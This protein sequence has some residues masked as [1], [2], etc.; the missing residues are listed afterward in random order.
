MDASER[1]SA[2]D[3]R[4]S[5]LQQFGITPEQGDSVTLDVGG[6]T[7]TYRVGDV[8]KPAPG[9]VLLILGERSTS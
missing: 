2:L 7:S 5:L 4:R 9:S 6:V 1:L 3:F 8:R